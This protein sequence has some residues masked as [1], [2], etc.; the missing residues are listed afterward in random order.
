MEQAT[1]LSRDL[2][3]MGHTVVS[4]LA[5][6]VDQAAHRGALVAGGPTIAVMPCGADRPYP[7]AH[8]QLL[9]AIAERGLVVAEA[10]P[11]AGPTR[12]RFLA[13]NR[14]VAGLAEGT[15]VV[16]GALRSGALNTAHWSTNL[17]RSL[18]GVP[19]PVTSAASAGVNQLIRLGQASMVATAQDVITD[20]T[21]HAYSASAA[22]DQLDESFV[23]GQVRSPLSQVPGLIAPAG[24][25][26]R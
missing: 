10:P 9:E 19:G 15:V 24:A 5:Y 8:A 7:A 23:P 26:R 6:G 2:A 21:T 20:L 11:G 22:H 18:M 13:R 1:E 3:A 16:E 14:I 12:T 25:P 17:H 4:G